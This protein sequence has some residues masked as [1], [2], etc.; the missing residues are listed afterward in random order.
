MKESKFFNNTMSTNM[1]NKQRELDSMKN[2]LGQLRE[3]IKLLANE[4]DNQLKALDESMLELEAQVASLIITQR[5]IAKVCK[6]ITILIGVALV[7]TI[8]SFLF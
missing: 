8:A 3:A 2:E 5:K 4:G 7:G 6:I 1:V